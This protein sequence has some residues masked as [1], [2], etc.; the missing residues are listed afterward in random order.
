MT[1]NG[2]FRSFLRRLLPLVDALLV[3]PTAL[4]AG[5]LL[6]VRRVGI[7][8][9]PATRQ[10][11]LRVGVFQL[12][13]H[14]YD[15][16][17]DHRTPLRPFSAER[18]LPGID[19]NGKEQ[20]HQLEAL[21]FAAELADLPR[22]PTG[23]LDFHLDND[24]FVAGDAEYWYQLLR[25][26]KPRRIFEIGSGHS[27]RMAIRALARNRAEDPEYS[28]RHVC[29]EPYE[30]PWLEQAGVEV[31]RS[32]VE[33]LD[34]AFFSELEAGDILFID[35]SH[36]IRPQGDVLFEYLELLP[37]LRP[38]VI[39]HVHDIFSPRNYLESWLVEGVKFWNEQYLLEAF[40][41]HNS[42]WKIIGALNWL[43]HNHS[44]ALKEVA[45]HL[46]PK[47]EPGSFYLRK[48]V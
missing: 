30:M 14:Y 17:F 45:P 9:L 27:T 44:D 1:A 35:S 28:C 4:A 20:L 7:R 22:Q 37:T 47:G 31:V 32:K 33:T 6:G 48:V 34:V 36:I 43:H 29:I 46:T 41:T 5:L 26:T 11:L 13:Q 8:R 2:I 38:G 24:A 16:Q 39:V 23:T 42:D 18:P 10:T 25:A 19:W 21:T 40:L 15:P 3:V 12:R